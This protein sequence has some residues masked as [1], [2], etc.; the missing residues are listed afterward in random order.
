MWYSSIYDCYAYYNSL[1]YE[2]DVGQQVDLICYN[3]TGSTIPVGSVVYITGQHSH[4]PTISLGQ[5]NALSTSGVVGIT[6]QAISNNS[7]GTVVILGQLNG[8]NTSGF[9]AGDILYLSP[10]TPGGIT[11][12]APT[13]PNYAVRV[14]FCVYSNPS[15]GVIFTSVR[16]SYV[17]TNNIVGQVPVAN[18]GTGAST[19]TGYVYG[20]GTSSMTASTTIPTTA[21]SGTIT[22]AQLANSSITINGTTTSLGGS[23]NVGTVTSVSGTAPVVSSGGSTPT[24]SMAAANSTT[25]G[26]LTSTDWN[27]FNNKSPAAGSTSIVTVG[28]ITT[29]VWNGTAIANS[30]LANS[31]ITINGTPVSLGG[32][33]TV[34]ASAGG[35]NTQVQYNSSGTF[36]GSANMTFDGTSLT[37]GNLIST[38]GL[39]GK[40]TFTG[41]YTD[42]IVVDYSTGNG[43][44]SVGTSD[45]LTFYN[46]GLANTTLGS[47]STSGLLQAVGGFQAPSTGPFFLNATTISANFTVPSN[48]NAVTAGKV[49]INTGV[50]VT[51]STGSRWVVV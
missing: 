2:I 40:A 39:Y 30:Y 37:A 26:Y 24:I 1:G 10:T 20:N 38:N 48:Y 14:G 44:I 35:S 36:A 42:G 3:S 25:N 6:G 28:T 31:S 27:T 9:T 29:G 33:T 49:T 8:V 21:L 50:T 43:R 12:T 34:S 22:N 13:S 41:S 47:F 17:A 7:N 5:A 18:G 51:V 23:I 11:N 15:Q 16:N 46:G 32:S 19:L 45:T 4:Q